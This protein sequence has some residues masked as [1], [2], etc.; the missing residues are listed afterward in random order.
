MILPTKKVPAKNVDKGSWI[1]IRDAEG[2][3]IETIILAYGVVAVNP[4]FPVEVIDSDKVMGKYETL[5]E[6]QKKI[7]LKTKL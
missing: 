6:E 2:K 4:E 7:I 3:Q 1:V 5:S